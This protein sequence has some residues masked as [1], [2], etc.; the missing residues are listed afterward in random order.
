MTHATYP[1]AAP[2]VSAFASGEPAKRG[3]LE[4]VQVGWMALIAAAERRLA[5]QRARR[6][7]RAMPDR[8]LRD[9][10]I[11]RSEIE[12]RIRCSRDGRR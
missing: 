3:L 4:H 11:D 9:F 8:A 7:L 6:E 1:A 5:L 2:R 10:G 12:W